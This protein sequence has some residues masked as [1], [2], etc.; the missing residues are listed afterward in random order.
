ML[1]PAVENLLC[2]IFS[3][4]LKGITRFEEVADILIS[5]LTQMNIYS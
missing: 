1:G 3:V 2:S 5:V 4:T